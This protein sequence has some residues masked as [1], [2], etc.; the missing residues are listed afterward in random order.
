MNKKKQ[1]TYDRL[2]QD[3]DFKEEYQ[4]E[5]KEFVLSE[6]LL[7]LMDGDNKSVRKLAKEA[8]LSANTIQNIRSGKQKDI[9][10]QSFKSIAEAYGYDL[11]LEKKGERIV[12]N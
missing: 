2:M 1:S 11:V 4:K 12:V 7:A 3:D 8:G 6:L 5:Y 10:L 9:R